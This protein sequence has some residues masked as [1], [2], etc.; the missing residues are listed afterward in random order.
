MNCK[1]EPP[2]PSEAAITLLANHPA[3][4][5]CPAFLLPDVQDA[6]EQQGGRVLSI[7]VPDDTTRLVCIDWPHGNHKP[8]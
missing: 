7:G 3:E 6:V 5:T 4:V 2:G 8:K 1:P